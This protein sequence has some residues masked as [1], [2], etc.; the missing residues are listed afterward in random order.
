MITVVASSSHNG[1]RA[2]ASSII[3]MPADLRQGEEGEEDEDDDDEW[4]Y[5][6]TIYQHECR[7]GGRRWCW[8][9]LQVRANE[10]FQSAT[11]ASPKHSRDDTKHQSPLQEG[12]RR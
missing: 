1:G 5:D 3:V 9:G 10:G 2:S 6:I 12:R 8:R 4:K 11:C 7:K